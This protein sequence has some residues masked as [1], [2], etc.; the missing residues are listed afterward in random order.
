MKTIMG[1][2]ETVIIGSGPG[3]YVAAIRAAQLGQKVTI[4]EKEYI[5]GVC[6]NVGCIPSKALVSAGNRYYEAIHSEVF[7]VRSTNVKIDFQKMQEWKDNKVIKPL[8]KGV[9]GLLK[10]NNVEIIRGTASFK[11]QKN[12]TVTTTE[13]E[14]EI[15]F[16]NVVVATGSKPVELLNEPYVIPFGKRV[17]DT[18]GGLNIQ[19]IPK[20]LIILGGGYVG[21]QLAGAFSNFGSKVTILEKDPKIISFFDDDLVQLVEKKFVEEEIT[22]ITDVTA[23]HS[24]ETDTGVMI[25]Y[26]ANGVPSTVEGDYV[27]VTV[28]RKPNTDQL[29]L[30]KA[31][32]ELTASGKLTVTEQLKST[33]P[34]IYGI[35]DVVPGRAFAHKASYEGKLVAEIISGGDAKVQEKAM[36][37]AVYTEPELATVGMTLKEAEVSEIKHTISKFPMKANGRALSLNQPAGFIR[38]ILH[39]DDE[40]VVGAQ[41]AGAGAADLIAELAL[42]IDMEMTAEDLARTIHAHPTL[43]ETVTDAAELAIG[44]SI[45]F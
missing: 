37:L 38:L 44:F 33:V 34:G 28:G 40:K 24:E 4:I 12:L 17:V 42:A 19:E 15:E 21:T 43:S 26:E 14:Q 11:N 3:G 31:G 8:T 27:L 29:N 9:E 20:H 7:G 6:L 35:G 25:R 5:G 41:V 13:G 23:A 22:V 16:E 18:T 36:P 10:K 2:K 30:K 32:V 45:H 39:P 1:K